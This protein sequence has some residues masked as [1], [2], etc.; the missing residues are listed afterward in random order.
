LTI[1]ASDLPRL[2]ADVAA[3]YRVIDVT[4]E[5]AGGDRSR[6]DRSVLRGRYA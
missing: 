6:S 5:R 1:T 2:P 3:R 4:L